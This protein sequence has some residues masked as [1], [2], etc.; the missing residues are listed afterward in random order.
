MDA[1][2]H[3]RMEHCVLAIDGLVCKTRCPTSKEVDF[4]LAYRNRNG[5]YGLVCFAGCDA[6][7]KFH[8]FSCKCSGST[9][10]VLAWDLSSIKALLDD[11]A[12]PLPYYFIGDEAFINTTKFLV[13]WGGSKLPEF[14]DSFN[15]AYHLSSMRQCIERA[16]ALLVQSWGILCKA[17]QLL[18]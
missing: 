13:P 15:R 2:S 11:N 7:L 10:G 4:P 18:H 12:L 16:F 8:M 6:H 9:N 17:S 1:Y 3:G 14:K 5:G